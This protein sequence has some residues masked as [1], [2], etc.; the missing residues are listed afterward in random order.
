M[1]LIGLSATLTGQILITWL[2]KRTGRSSLLVFTLALL[3]VLA[4]GAGV[5]VV[6]LALAAVV[7]DPSLLWATRKAHMCG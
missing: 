5:S 7:K 1:T 3:F 6:G 2:V 4:F